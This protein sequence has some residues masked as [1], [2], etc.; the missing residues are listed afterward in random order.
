MKRKIYKFLF[1]VFISSWIFLSYFGASVLALTEEDEPFRI[2]DFESIVV[3]I[4]IA[5]WALSIPYFMFVIISI[6]ASWMLSGGDEQK[7]GSLKTRAGNVML[8]FFLLFGGYL[9]VKI[10]ISFLGLKDPNDCFK[11][12]LGGSP[13]FQFF[14]K[15]ACRPEDIYGN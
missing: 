11:S 1:T 12:P 7:L 9:I 13:I 2:R 6:G 10:V 3:N 14:F 5:I 15:E 4:L 8:S